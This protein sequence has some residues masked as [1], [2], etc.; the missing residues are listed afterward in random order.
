MHIYVEGCKDLAWAI[1][2]NADNFP[3]T[4]VENSIDFAAAV[5]AFAS[6]INVVT[7]ITIQNSLL[8]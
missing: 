3:V 1:P 2:I 6:K 7:P 8:L 5:F 4:Q